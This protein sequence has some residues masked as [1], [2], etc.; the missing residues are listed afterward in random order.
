MSGRWAQTLRQQAVR[1][2]VPFIAESAPQAGG[3]YLGPANWARSRDLRRHPGSDIAAQADRAEILLISLDELTNATDRM[4]GFLA[5]FRQTFPGQVTAH[6]VQGRGFLKDVIRQSRD[7][8]RTHPGINVVFGVNDHT[9]LG[10]LEV[11]ER[12]GHDVA[13]YS[14]GG[15]GDALFDAL[16][17][18]GR[19]RATLALFPE[20]VGR[21]AID[22]VGR[23]FAGE[24][25]GEAVITP[26]VVLT[27]ETL[28][29]FYRSEADHWR[30]DP[31]VLD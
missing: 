11:A 28:P 1:S 17:S 31:V 14:V 3:L 8:F 12:M 27:P 15:E 4:N 10:A 2:R 23:C 29:D 16:A 9:I 22:T 30:L 21:V 20:V 13:A 5:G 7:A 19:L 6:Q 26:A 24:P 18:G 25:A